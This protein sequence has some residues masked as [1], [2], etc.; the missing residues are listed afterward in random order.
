MTGN[1]ISFY[2]R[3]YLR[4]LLLIALSAI[5][6]LLVFPRH[7][8]EFVSYDSTKTLE[9]PMP[10]QSE[11]PHF[12]ST[13]LIEPPINSNFI[14]PSKLNYLYISLDMQEVVTASWEPYWTVIPI[15]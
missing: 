5:V 9:V 6:F 7:S 14:P 10:S 4:V 15:L 1:I 8:N 11:S 3:P 12:P 2:F 13:P